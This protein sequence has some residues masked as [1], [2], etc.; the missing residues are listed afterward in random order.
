[1][2][3]QR[4]YKPMYFYTN[5]KDEAKALAVRIKLSANENKEL[6]SNAVQQVMKLES[7]MEFKNLWRKVEQAHSQKLL[8]MIS[9]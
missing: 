1:M 5:D 9:F 3:L 4:D 7:V 8:K 2:L 6:I